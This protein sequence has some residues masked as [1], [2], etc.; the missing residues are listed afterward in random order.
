MCNKLTSF[1]QGRVVTLPPTSK[2]TLKKPTEVRVNL[3]LVNTHSYNTRTCENI[4]KY[5]CRTDAFKHSFFPWT[6]V[7][8]NKLDLPCRRSTYNVF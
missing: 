8:W 1:R 5:H 6:I 4:T 7:E 2:Q 3:I